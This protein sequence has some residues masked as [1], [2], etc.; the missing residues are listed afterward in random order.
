MTDDI[1]RSLWSP[2]M[3]DDAAARTSDPVAASDLRRLAA[4]LRMRGA[5]NIAAAWPPDLPLGVN[6]DNFDRAEADERLMA[7]RD[8]W[9]FSMFED[10][11]G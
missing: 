3:W 11:L 4:T 10:D 1:D 2:G 7:A 5:V 8:A 9:R 6:T